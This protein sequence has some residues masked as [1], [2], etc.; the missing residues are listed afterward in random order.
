M[1][2]ERS[3][4]TE[5]SSCNVL[6]KKQKI[7]HIPVIEASKGSRLCCIRVLSDSDSCGEIELYWTEKDSHTDGF[8]NTIRE[9]LKAKTSW[10]VANGFRMVVNRR[11]SRDNDR[12]CINSTPSS[13]NNTNGKQIPRVYWLRLV[14]SST[15]ESRHIFGKKLV[16]V[17]AN[18][19]P[20]RSYRPQRL[21]PKLILSSSVTNVTDTPSFF[22]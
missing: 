13:T 21:S 17:I 22:F 10:G 3:Q 6:T 15:Q 20:D 11:I 16:K 18:V 8:M 4:N 1:S 2:E 14:P 5:E 19:S 7:D 9:D 12:P